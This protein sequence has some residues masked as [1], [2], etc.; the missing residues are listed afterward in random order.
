MVLPFWR[1]PGGAIFASS[2]TWSKNVLIS[3]A[4]HHEHCEMLESFL[5]SKYGIHRDPEDNQLEDN[6]QEDNIYLANL[7]NFNVSYVVIN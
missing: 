1:N 3:I 4:F 7:L 2:L 6:K 5:R